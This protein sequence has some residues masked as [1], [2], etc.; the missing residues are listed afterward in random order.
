MLDFSLSHDTAVLPASDTLLAAL[1]G[2]SPF[3]MTLS[4][5]RTADELAQ[6]R[7]FLDALA[8]L[9]S[10]TVELHGSSL[11]FPGPDSQLRLLVF[12]PEGEPSAALLHIHGGG[13]FCGS[14]EMSASQLQAF[15]SEMNLLVASVDYRL[16]PEHRYP[17]AVDDCEAAALWW[18]DYAAERF[19][20]KQL[21]IAGES[22][23][24]HLAAVTAMRLR[25][26]H[27]YS[28]AGLLLTYGMYDFTNGLPSR[29]VVDGRNLVQDSAMCDFYASNFVPDEKLRRSADVSPLYADMRGLP[30]A[31]LIVGELDPFYDD[32]LLLHARSVGDGNRSYLAIFKH[33]PHGFEVFDPE[34]G[35][36]C[37]RLGH[38]FVESCL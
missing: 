27:D 28:A 32:S 3:G 29:S 37:R 18:R 33:A 8:S 34:S 19:G 9:Q 15:A 4:P 35:N 16:A 38:A 11:T 7:E 24:A 21:F 20:L 5:P 36:I 17:A 22:A 26:K 12:E 23:G 2:D 13:W 10:D 31:L 30:P 25:D 14:P 6:S 1:E